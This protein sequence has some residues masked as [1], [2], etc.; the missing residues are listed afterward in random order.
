MPWI[1]SHSRSI[2]VMIANL[3]NSTKVSRTR[4][5]IVHTKER[6]TACPKLNAALCD[7]SARLARDPAYQRLVPQVDCVPG[8]KEG[9]LAATAQLGRLLV[10]AG[11][12]D[13][14]DQLYR[15]LAEQFP[16]AP[17]GF[18]GM[19]QVAVKR[20]DWAEA[21]VRWQTVLARF[22]AGKQAFW[23]ASFATALIETGR[24]DEAEKVF[25]DLLRD[26]GDD[27]HGVL[28]LA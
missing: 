9:I 16:H 18:V 4:I 24:L 13:E 22:S 15:A 14:A 21:L 26:F 12:L 17:P 25:R 10:D 3:G 8:S 27:P 2:H 6:T 7:I 1:G 28:G 11:L 23:M 5:S 20:W 19:A